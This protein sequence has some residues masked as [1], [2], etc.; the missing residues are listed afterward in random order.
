MLMGYKLF[1]SFFVSLA[2]LNYGWATECDL[3]YQIDEDQWICR[4]VN[5][6]NGEYFEKITDLI[7]E[8]EERLKLERIYR[9]FKP[10]VLK[11]ISQT[12][13]YENGQEEDVEICSLSLG[14][15]CNGVSFFQNPQ[16]D[17]C[18]PLHETKRL[19]NGNWAHTSFEEDYGLKLVEVKDS[20][21]EETLLTMSFSYQMKDEAID[22]IVNTNQGKQIVY[23]F[24]IYKDGYQLFGL[25]GLDKSLKIHY[26]ENEVQFENG[27]KLVSSVEFDEH[28]RV[29]ILKRSFD[30]NLT[31]IYE[32]KYYPAYT[33][34]L[35]T[36]K[37]KTLYRFDSL[38]RLCQIEKYDF[39]QK[40]HCVERKFWYGNPSLN[41]LLK[42]KTVE[43]ANGKI[44][45]YLSYKYNQQGKLVEESF[46]GN[47]TG[48]A[49]YH[50]QVDLEGNLLNP[51]VKECCKTE[52]EYDSFGKVKTFKRG[53]RDRIDYEYHPESQQLLKK[54]I[55][56]ND[57]LVR[58]N[59]YTYDQKG[60]LVRFVED[61]GSSKEDD[62]NVTEKYIADYG[63]RKLG[64]GGFEKSSTYKTFDF[65][66][67]C[68]TLTYRSLFIHDAKGNLVR[69]ENYDAEGV[70][71]YCFDRK[72]DEQNQIIYEKDFWGSE[73]H[74]EYDK[75]GNQI[76]L[77]VPQEQ[78]MTLTEYNEHHLPVKTI[79]ISQGV[80]YEYSYAYDAHG[81]QY[82]WKS[83][84]NEESRYEYD[85]FGNVIKLVF[86]QKEPEEKIIMTSYEYDVL[87]FQ[88]QRDS[89]EEGKVVQKNNVKGN[90]VHIAYQ[91]GSFESFLYDS[92]GFLI[93]HI[94]T[95]GVATDYAYDEQGRCLQ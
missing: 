73:Y 79:E 59:F 38:G 13:N 49:D 41:S 28:K 89:Q 81:R 29:K 85:A 34:A 30:N 43:D 56:L 4:N 2:L 9:P 12:I 44:Y 3:N 84:K 72:Y 15:Y 46:Y 58:R 52:F 18:Q 53:K 60:F 91:D 45:T 31:P 67:N 87:G 42:A 7:V 47:I 19:P 77:E 55:Y 83:N 93:K 14:N 1:F 69:H 75:N 64:E 66:S 6:K 26:L 23:H 63:Q 8:A 32:F 35:S 62:S 50:P 20:L 17:V 37:A 68:E 24:E 10:L 71:N 51:E 82:G 70:L 76:K 54:W 90:P 74:F 36:T 33:E 22:L 11:V 94:D 61:N 5:S 92:E 48:E 86:S 78:R 39:N 80:H 27:N 88:T 25:S 57:Q 40:L 16:P 21:N 95:N 65:D